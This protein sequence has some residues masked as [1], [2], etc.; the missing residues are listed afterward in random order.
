MH[1]KTFT[2]LITIA[3]H[4]GDEMP[5][6]FAISERIAVALEGRAPLAYP[7][8][9]ACHASA[10]QGDVILNPFLSNQTID[11]GNPMKLN[12]LGH[13]CQMV[14]DQHALIHSRGMTPNTIPHPS[15]NEGSDID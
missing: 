11:K 12:A 13:T 14:R 2:A 3:V 7:P 9:A 15:L 1:L 6:E 5:H 10:I 8:V 4:D